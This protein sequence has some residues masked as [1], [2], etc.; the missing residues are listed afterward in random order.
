MIDD[1]LLFA[2]VPYVAAVALVV[3]CA[4]RFT[5]ATS[6]LRAIDR[7]RARRQARARIVVGGAV[8]GIVVLHVTLLAAPAAVLRWNTS[9][10]RLL[11]LESIGMGCGLICAVAAVLKIRRLVLDDMREE[12]RARKHRQRVIDLIAMTLAGVAV[13]SGVALAVLYRWASSWSVVTL[14]PY[15][16]SLLQGRPRVEL[17][18]SMPFL[19]RLHV[20]S[21]F[22]LAALLPLTLLASRM[23]AAVA[24]CLQ[25]IARPVTPAAGLTRRAR[26]LIQA[27][28]DTIQ[29]WIRRNVRPGAFW[30]EEES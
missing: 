16:A 20:F 12:R 3:L 8:V 9:T 13:V 30:H 6:V 17:V 2:V 29:D 14:T 10:A 18:A 15:A 4:I 28:A 7:R 1:Y 23:L 21:T 19:V 5:T 24:R 27:P 26:R 11:L 25:L 22:A